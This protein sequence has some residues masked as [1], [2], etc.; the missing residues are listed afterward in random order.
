MH[1]TTNASRPWHAVLEPTALGGTPETAEYPDARA[2]P[3]IG[4]RLAVLGCASVASITIPHGGRILLDSSIPCPEGGWL[5]RARPLIELLGQRVGVRATAGSVTGRI[6]GL[7]PADLR[8]G[9]LEVSGRI[10]G[11]YLILGCGGVKDD[12]A[13]VIGQGF[14][15]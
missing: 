11:L 4:T 10:D 8:R 6:N 14:A 9:E 15:E 3:G 12:L 2:I 1:T 5:E 13:L 7:L